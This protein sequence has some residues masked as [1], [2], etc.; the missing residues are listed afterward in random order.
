MIFFLNSLLLSFAKLCCFDS[1]MDILTRALS[2]S[3][4]FS[5]IFFFHYF[6]HSSLP[7][8][9]TPLLWVSLCLGGRF[10]FDI[11]WGVVGNHAPLFLFFALFLVLFV[12]GFTGQFCKSFVFFSSG[13]HYFLAERLRAQKGLRLFACVSV[14]WLSWI[15]RKGVEYVCVCVSEWF[16]FR[17]FGIVL[18]F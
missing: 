10:W 13:T 18:S 7:W 11:W 16:T 8:W 1:N 6:A 4:V 2:L 3:L 12:G 5:V 14:L 17:L 9:V 15:P